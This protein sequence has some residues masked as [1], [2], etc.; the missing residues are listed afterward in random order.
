M[1][2]STNDPFKWLSSEL[3]AAALLNL[4]PKL[5]RGVT[6]AL[7][8]EPEVLIALRALNP[9]SG[10]RNSFQTSIKHPERE[11]FVHRICSYQGPIRDPI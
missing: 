11:F 2:R 6:I 3:K 7:F 9:D 1:R 8:Y 10:K 5:D 4:A